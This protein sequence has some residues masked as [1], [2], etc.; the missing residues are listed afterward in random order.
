MTLEKFI[1]RTEMKSPF[2]HPILVGWHPDSEGKK[3]RPIY[4]KYLC[5]K[6]ESGY[7]LKKSSLEKLKSRCFSRKK[8]E[9]KLVDKYLIMSSEKP[10]FFY[11]FY[12]EP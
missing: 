3:E 11:R 9:V 8:T 10:R 1:K 5:Y 12:L 4:R 6:L 7:K 2:K